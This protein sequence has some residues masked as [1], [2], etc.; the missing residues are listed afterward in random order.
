M[1]EIEYFKKSWIN[2][3]FYYYDIFQ[4]DISSTKPAKFSR[5][6]SETMVKFENPTEITV[7]RGHVLYKEM[8]PTIANQI[9]NVSY[10]C[11]DSDSANVYCLYEWN[12]ENP[13]SDE[14]TNDEDFYAQYRNEIGNIEND[15]RHL[16][17]IR[18]NLL[19][20]IVAYQ[21]VVHD[22]TAYSF[23]VNLTNK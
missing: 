19:S 3:H 11:T 23:R 10:I 22:S 13:H 8:H 14:K 18:H 21:C 9:L 15:I 6:I 7:R 4:S 20:K 1:R 17:N 16:I 2:F 12:F 5:I